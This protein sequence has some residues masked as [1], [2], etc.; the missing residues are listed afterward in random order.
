MVNEKTMRIKEDFERTKM[1]K[2]KSNAGRTGANVLHE[3]ERES[4]F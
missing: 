3:R 4:Q 1:L 2:T